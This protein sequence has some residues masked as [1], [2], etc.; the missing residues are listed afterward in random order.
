MWFSS[1][2]QLRDSRSCLFPEAFDFSNE[3]NIVFVQLLWPIFCN[4]DLKHAVPLCPPFP[5]SRRLFCGVVGAWVG[6]GWTLRVLPSF[7]SREFNCGNPAVDSIFVRYSLTV[8]SFT[9]I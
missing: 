7:P 3:V 8:L 9:P 5:T 4:A 1:G 6:F 2:V